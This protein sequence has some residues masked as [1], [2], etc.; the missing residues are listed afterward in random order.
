M[1][2]CNSIIQLVGTLNNESAITTCSHNSPI[3]HVYCCIFLLNM[4]I[5]SILDLTLRDKDLDVDVHRTLPPTLGEIS[6]TTR[7]R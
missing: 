4:G 7:I 2:R 5:R 1:Q 6:E 3:I